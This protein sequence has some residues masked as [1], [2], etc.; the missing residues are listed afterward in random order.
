MDCLQALRKPSPFG[1]WELDMPLALS[2]FIA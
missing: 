1:Y 2:R